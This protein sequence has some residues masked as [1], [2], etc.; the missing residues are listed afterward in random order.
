MLAESTGKQGKGIVPIA[1]EPLGDPSSYGSD[2]LFVYLRDTAAPDAAQDSAVEALERAGQPVVRI[3][4]ASP[5]LIAQ[6][7][8]RF[9]IATAV[10]G[11]IL[12]I[13]PF[14]QPD[15][16]AAKIAARELT[17]AYE[18]SGSL[19]A[20]IPVFK[21]NGIALYTDER[22]AQSLRQAG[23]DAT[24]ESWLGAHFSRIHDGDYF[25]VLAYVERNAAHFHTLEG[26]RTTIR[27][28]RR[29]ATS[30]QFGPRYL[31][32]TGQVHKGGPN[33]GVFL[34]ITSDSAADVAIP[35][36]NASFAVVEA[37]QAAGDFRVLAQR[38]RRVLRAHLAHDTDAGLAALSKAARQALR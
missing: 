34:Q 4:L 14:D 20:G 23:A 30:V 10:A 26:L 35:G 5:Q 21:Q 27:D 7:F 37:A 36:R 22:N 1:D 33:S 28:A 17:E 6:E 9:E 3:R 8:F 15:V 31:H 2:R 13:N 29:I 12:G 18:K 16:E 25:A 19:P 38:G 24:L 32:S 11:S